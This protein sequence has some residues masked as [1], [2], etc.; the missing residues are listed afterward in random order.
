MKVLD[1]QKRRI[2]NKHYVSGTA[3]LGTA[4]GAPGPA[5]GKQRAGAAGP[6]GAPGWWEEEEEEEEG[7]AAGAVPVPGPI[8]HPGK[9]GGECG[10]GCARGCCWGWGVLGQ[11]APLESPPESVPALVRGS[12]W[13][14]SQEPVGCG[15]PAE[16]PP[17]SILL[18]LRWCCCPPLRWLR[19]HCTPAAPLSWGAHSC[20]LQ[21]IFPTA[22]GLS[23]SLFFFFYCCCCC[24]LHFGALPGIHGDLVGESWQQL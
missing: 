3:R 4:R 14:G 2:P 9:V 18:C 6:R 19:A 17:G 22:A 13:G 5:L 23:F 24:Y 10:W 12:V 16:G 1:V 20:T 7:S 8:P 11:P 21:G 15:V